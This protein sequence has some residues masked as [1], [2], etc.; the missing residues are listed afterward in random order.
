M[1]YVSKMPYHI[2]NDDDHIDTLCINAKT[3][4]QFIRDKCWT[5]YKG[6]EV[7]WIKANF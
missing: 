2:H 7:F 3:L 1:W 4:Q 5:T 6:F